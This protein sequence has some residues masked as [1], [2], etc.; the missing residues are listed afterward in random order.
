MATSEEEKKLQAEKKETGK[1]QQE[2]NSYA[3]KARELSALLTIE[4][5]TLGQELKEHLGI[6]QRTNDFDKALLKVARSITAASEQNA[7]ALGRSGDIAKAIL[8]DQI[9]LENALR[10][11]QISKIG[12]ANDQVGLA[13][14]VNKFNRQALKLQEEIEQKI[15][16]SVDLEGTARKDAEK[17]IQALKAK[18]A[19]KEGDLQDALARLKPAGQ[20][21]ALAL[22]ATEQAKK[23]KANTPKVA[24]ALSKNFGYLIFISFKI[25]ALR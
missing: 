24:N 9:N 25:K 21:Y 16:D 19:I 15:S 2:N 13:V 11:A 22:Q 18:Q 8:K 20:T 10:E 23:I 7:V 5:R 1:I 3:D 6:K 4:N 14:R 17:D 12:L